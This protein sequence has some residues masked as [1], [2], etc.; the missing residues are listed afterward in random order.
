MDHLD[1]AA[2][3]VYSS[4]VPTR[5][6]SVSSTDRDVWDA[7]LPVGS[8]SVMTAAQTAIGFAGGE[9]RSTRNGPPL[10][11]GPQGGW[12]RDPIDALEVFE[13]IR[14]LNDPEH[15]LTLEQLNVAALDHIAVDD[16]ASTVDVQFTP[17]IPHCA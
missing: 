7:V 17:T 6:Y 16:L 4:S 9:A 8:V 14:H 5:A 10:P 1:N 13:H 3:T 15:P 11:A 2:P 12:R